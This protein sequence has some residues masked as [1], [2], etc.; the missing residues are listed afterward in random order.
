MDDGVVKGTDDEGRTRR[1]GKGNKHRIQS[2]PEEIKERN[3]PRKPTGS[4]MLRGGYGSDLC[5]GVVENFKISP[6]SM[7]EKQEGRKKERKRT[8]DWRQ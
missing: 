2:L 7:E 4:R 6:E 1:E 5:E 3:I 8:G